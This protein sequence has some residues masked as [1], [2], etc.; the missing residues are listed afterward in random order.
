LFAGWNN[1][2][3]NGTRFPSQVRVKEYNMCK[4]LHERC[5]IP[6]SATFKSYW[7]FGGG[8][9]IFYVVDA[10]CTDIRMSWLVLICW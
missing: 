4:P 3:G 6:L 10:L 8:F 7:R 5:V 1:G 9:S 2:V